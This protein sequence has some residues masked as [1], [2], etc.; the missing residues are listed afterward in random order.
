MAPP[1]QAA[2]PAFLSPLR[3]TGAQRADTREGR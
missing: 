1:A 2:A 3:G